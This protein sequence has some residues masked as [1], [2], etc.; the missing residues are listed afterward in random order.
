M[1]LTKCLRINSFYKRFCDF[2]FGTLKLNYAVQVCKNLIC[3]S[4]FF[5]S[6]IRRANHFGRLRKG[7]SFVIRKILKRLKARHMKPITTDQGIQL[8]QQ[9][10]VPY[11]E[12]SATSGSALKRYNSKEMDI[13][14]VSALFD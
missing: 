12:V 5:F 7:P 13:N 8:S 6:L 10:D 11:F 9:L 14:F 1:K 2:S 4:S 3:N